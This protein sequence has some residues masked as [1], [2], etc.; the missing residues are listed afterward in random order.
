VAEERGAPRVQAVVHASNAGMLRI[1]SA[2]CE[3]PGHRLHRE[4]DGGLLT[5]IVA[6]ATP[7]SS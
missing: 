7:T 3:E 6:L 4:Y 1:M 5:L 2:L